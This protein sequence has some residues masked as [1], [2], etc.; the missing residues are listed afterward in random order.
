[1]ATMFADVVERLQFTRLVT[2]GKNTLALDLGCNISART[3]QLLLVTQKL[4][5]VVKDMLALD[6]GKKRI[7]IASGMNR[8]RARR[9]GIESLTDLG[10]GGLIEFRNAHECSSPR[11]CSMYDTA[12]TCLVSFLNVPL[13]YFQLDIHGSE[14]Y[15]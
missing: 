1:M 13:G 2:T 5:A 3:G 8:M 9:N 7:L 10:E 4:P 11:L 15:R 12:F 6:L 14:L